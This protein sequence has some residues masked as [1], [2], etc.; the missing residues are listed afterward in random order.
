[1]TNKHNKILGN[2]GEDAVCDYLK[3]KG[4]KIVKRNFRCRQGEVD[5]IVENNDCLIFVEV[6]TRKNS[7]FG[8][9]AEAVD[10]RKIQK[11]TKVIQY[12]L[13]YNDWIGDVRVDVVEVIGNIKLGRFNVDSINH[14]KNVV[15]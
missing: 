13:M 4:Y 15:N 11:I 3:D 1:M 6:K 2:F 5:I 9:P 14:I 12:Y 8:E 10:F 7:E